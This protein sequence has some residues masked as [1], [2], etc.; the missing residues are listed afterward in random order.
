M[1]RSAEKPTVKKEGRKKRP[2]PNR[3]SSAQCAAEELSG[4]QADA[5]R[6]AKVCGRIL[7]GLKADLMRMDDPRQP[8][9]VKHPLYAVLLYGIFAFML[10]A[11]SRREINRAMSSPIAIGNLGAISEA[12]DAAPHA[13]TLARLLKAINAESVQD[14]YARLLK[15]LLGLKEFKHLAA[16]HGRFVVAVDGSMKYSRDYEF[17]GHAVHRRVGEGDKEIYGVYVLESTLVLSNGAVLPLLVEFVENH[18]LGSDAEKQD[19]ETK[20]F[21]RMAPRLARLL[22]RNVTIL[23]DSL[24]ATGPIVSLIGSRGWEYAMTLKQGALP[25]VWEEAVGLMKADPANSLSV[26]YGSGIRQEFRWANGIEHIYGGNHRRLCVNAVMLDEECED[27]H[28]R[29]GGKTEKRRSRHA[30]LTSSTVSKGNV[31]LLCNDI[32]RKRWTIEN[33]FKSEKYDGSMFAHC[34]SLDWNTLKGFH[35]LMKIGRALA[36]IVA[37]SEL[38]AGIARDKGFGGFVSYLRLVVIGCVL[39]LEAIRNAARAPFRLRMNPS[40][41]PPNA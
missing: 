36:V 15:R 13:D 8:G 30:W 22:G 2:V 27:L 1:R 19:C 3:K 11:G 24:Y 25:A 18:P 21:K 31:D 20:A 34:F 40:I 32:A 14:C 6:F 12:I 10:R 16:P 41:P 35:Y 29:S 17:S 33:E 5:E 28:T 39:D 4:R 26:E 7:P 38:F 23:A 37:S 9:K